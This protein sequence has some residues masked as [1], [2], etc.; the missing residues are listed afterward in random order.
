MILLSCFQLVSVFKAVSFFL[1]FLSLF[2]FL[3]PQ[4]FFLPI[5]D[6]FFA[7]FLGYF[8]FLSNTIFYIY[9]LPS[10]SLFT[11]SQN[12]F[13]LLLRTLRFSSTFII[14]V[15]QLNLSSF[16]PISNQLVSCSS[17]H[18]TILIHYH[19]HAS[20]Y[21]SFYIYAYILRFLC[22]FCT[23]TFT[24]NATFKLFHFLTCSAISWPIVIPSSFKAIPR[25]PSSHFSFCSFISNQP[26]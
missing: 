25:F 17:H 19:C 6:H 1:H 5:F 16:A 8:V 3:R 20:H 26:C 24:S 15:R 2:S 9:V 22:S 10:S 23:A 12:L 13:F 11:L 7:F 21:S 18:Y 4:I 14:S